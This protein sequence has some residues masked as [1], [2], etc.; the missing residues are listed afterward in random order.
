MRGA[1]AA[2]S[3]GGAALSSL[4]GAADDVRAISKG[5]ALPVWAWAVVAIT[6][7]VAAAQTARAAN[8]GTSFLGIN[9]LLKIAKARIKARGG[10]NR[11]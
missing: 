5:L 6:P 4:R 10:M 11:R 2:L 3:A 1:G 7:A 8:K 9:R